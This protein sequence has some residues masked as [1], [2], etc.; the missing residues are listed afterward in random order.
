MSFD[1]IWYDLLVEKGVEE[2]CKIYVD[3]NMKAC[4]KGELK[5]YIEAIHDTMEKID[6]ILM[7]TLEE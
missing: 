6:D 2:A 3:A 4:F 5:D 1:S 7:D